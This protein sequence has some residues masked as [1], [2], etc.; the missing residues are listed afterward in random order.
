MSRGK[1]G[2]LTPSKPHIS[3]DR[4]NGDRDI[5]KKILK[6]VL[7]DTLSRVHIV[8]QELRLGRNKEEER[9]REREKTK[10]QKDMGTVTT[11]KNIQDEEMEIK[12][13][14][15]QNHTIYLHNLQIHP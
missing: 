14:P 11:L 12:T 9:P 6:T 4:G 15:K 7:S 5:P 2:S 3:W 8:E 13:D 1:K 10:P